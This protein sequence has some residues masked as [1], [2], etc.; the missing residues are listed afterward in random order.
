MQNLRVRETQFLVSRVHL[1]TYLREIL[2]KYGEIFYILFCTSMEYLC[3]SLRLS[4]YV[5]N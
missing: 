4:R 5:V 3:Q 1:Y 2:T